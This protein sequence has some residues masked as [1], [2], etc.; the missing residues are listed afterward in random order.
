M[1]L[2]TDNCSWI[3]HVLTRKMGGLRKPNIHF[4]IERSECL[5]RANLACKTA[6]VR[7]AQMRVCSASVRFL[8]AR[9]AKTQRAVAGNGRCQWRAPSSD[10]EPQVSDS[11]SVGPFFIASLQL[12]SATVA[13]PCWA[14]TRRQAQGSLLRFLKPSFETLFSL[15]PHFPCPLFLI[16]SI[17]EKQ[18]TP[19]SSGG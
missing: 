10:K 7:V 5:F 16:F 1:C 12:G 18:N 11:T 19:I 9:E 13:G 2:R 6:F 17:V 15:F 14:I 8:L 3:S 4:C